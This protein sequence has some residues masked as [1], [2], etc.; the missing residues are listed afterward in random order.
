MTT[1][2]ILLLLLFALLLPA[3]AAG[4]PPKAPDKPAAADKKGEKKLP[5]VE[6]LKLQLIA[7][8]QEN[9]R[10]TQQVVGLQKQLQDALAQNQLRE[11]QDQQNALLKKAGVG[12]DQVVDRQT[13][14]V[15]PRP[16]APPAK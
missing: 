4:A 14:V 2:P 9:A 11:L 7:V 12:E 6:L 16:P 1:R 13:G 10:L 3:T 8:A 15:S 5:E